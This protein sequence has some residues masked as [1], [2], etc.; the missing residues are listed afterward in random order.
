[1]IGLLLGVALAGTVTDHRG[2]SVTA[3]S[4]QRVVAL[5]GTLTEIVY[6]L[7]AQAQL[8][9]VDASSVYPQAATEQPQVGYY[10]QVGAEGLLSLRPDLIIASEDAGPPE[11]LALVEAAGVPLAVLSSEPS[12]DAAKGRIAAVATLLDREAKGEAL[13]SAMSAALEGLAPAQPRPRVV[14]LFG[15]G[16]GSLLVAGSDTAAAAMIELAGGVS[17]VSEYSGYR[18]LT[19]EALVAADPDVVVST[20]RVVEGLGGVEALTAI[21]AL[22]ACRA[23]LQGRIVVLDDLMMLGFGPRTGEGARR[24]HEALTP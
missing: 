5:G 4:P 18:P 10:R 8:A 11:A 22:A 15:R 20:T 13:V 6:A 2:T 7:G 24:L 19:P 1:M 3:S 23:V 12:V 9:G 17:A 16:G 21:P 14:F